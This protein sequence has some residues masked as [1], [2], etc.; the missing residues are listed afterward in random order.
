MMFKSGDC[1]GQEDVDVNLR[2]LQTITEQFR[3]CKWGH[4]CDRTPSITH[5]SITFNNQR[6][7]NCSPT[8]DVGFVKLTLD[9]FCGNRFFK[10]FSSAVTCAA[11]VL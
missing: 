10:I 5:L 9:S 7:Y 2:A 4:G 6:F 3:L 11:V 1:A 8:V